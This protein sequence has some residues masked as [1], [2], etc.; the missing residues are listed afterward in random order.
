M[1]VMNSD[2]SI[3]IYHLGMSWQIDERMF[4]EKN[5]N[6]NNFYTL[7][8]S[9]ALKILVI[10]KPEIPRK[11]VQQLYLQNKE[12][13]GTNKGS[14]LICPTLNETKKDKIIQFQDKATITRL[15]TIKRQSIYF[16]IFQV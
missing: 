14:F 1:E 4:A 10:R 3:K 5:T 2:L 15:S 6:S 11:V 12:D 8:T 13:N 9:I 7:P 16:R